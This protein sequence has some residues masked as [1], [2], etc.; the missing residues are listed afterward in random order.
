MPTRFRLPRPVLA[1][2]C[3][4][5]ATAAAA[6]VKPGETLYVKTRNTRVLKSPSAS[7]AVVVVLQPGAPVTWEGPDPTDGRWQRVTSG[8]KQGVVMTA[9]LAA[10]PPK[11]EVTQIT[12]AT[13]SD[14]KAAMSTGA[15][16]RALGAGALAYAKE[17]GSETAAK[18]LERAEV[19][20]RTIGPKQVAEHAKKAGIHSIVGASAGVAEAKP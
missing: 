19:L 15:A 1:A 7:A 14:A 9:N 13:S 4:L 8:K 12:G 17:L 6:G 16:S 18:Q 3:A 10:E 5:L 11:P 2:V 20:A